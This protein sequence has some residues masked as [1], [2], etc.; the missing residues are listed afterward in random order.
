MKAHA[1][2]GEAPLDAAR[3]ERT[4]RRRVRRLQR[5]GQE[6]EHAVET[7]QVVLKRRGAGGERLQRAEQHRQVD[8]KHHQVADRQPSLE[9]LR[10]A[11]DEEG[12]R[13]QRNQHFPDE[14][15]QPRPPPDEQLLADHQVVA[16]DEAVGFAP[17]AAVG[18][19]DAHAAERFGR[20]AVD[21]LP[22]RADVAIERPDAVD[23]GAMAHIDG[24]N[25]QEAEEGHP[26]IDPGE[27]D[28][29]A[30][31]LQDRPP[32]VV[33]HA[34]DQLRHAAG[35]VAQEARRPARLELIH[36]VQRQPHGVGE[37]A[38]ANGDLKSIDRLGGEPAAAQMNGRGQDG[39]C[40]D[41]RRRRDT[42]LESGRWAGAAFRSTRPAAGDRSGRC[43]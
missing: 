1:R 19:H 13:G 14:L 38:A 17:L 41:K 21:V 24:R 40:G 37:D 31:Q 34:E 7:G 43:R 28:Q 32:R 27:H 29:A 25:E 35:I 20:L 12:N 2:E 8:Q 23:P 9:H 3:I 39:H 33:E 26:P 11:V 22:L 30:D 16:G 36:A 15:D 18:P 10:A 4:C 5:L 6:I 42:E